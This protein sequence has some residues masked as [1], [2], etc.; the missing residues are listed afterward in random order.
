MCSSG[1]GRRNGSEYHESNHNLSRSESIAKRSAD[2]SNNKC[3]T[4]TE[5]VAVGDVDVG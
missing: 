1:E 3:C 4:Q 5:N 2:D